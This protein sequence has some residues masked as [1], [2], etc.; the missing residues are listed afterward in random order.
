MIIQ[1]K[2]ETETIE[3]GARV[4]SYLKGGEIIYLKGELGTG[5]T[6]FVRGVLNGLGHTGNVKSPTFTIVEQYSIDNHVIYHFDLY[7][8]DDPEELESL[9]I[10]DYCDGQSICFFEWPEKGGNLL[11]NADIN[12]ELTYLENTREVEFTSKSEVGKSILKQLS[13]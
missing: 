9:G 7:R 2:N 12:L 10:R 6:T 11:P 4:A 3:I 5:K 8:L 13:K 1:L